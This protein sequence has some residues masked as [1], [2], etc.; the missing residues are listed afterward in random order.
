MVLG[1][2]GDLKLSVRATVL[3]ARIS[4]FLLELHHLYLLLGG[5]NVI[6]LHIDIHV[7]ENANNILREISPFCAEGP[8]MSRVTRK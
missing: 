8:K 1:Q 4:L 6:F 7:V 5:K 3:I 2:E